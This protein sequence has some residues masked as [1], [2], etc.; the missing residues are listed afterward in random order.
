MTGRPGRVPRIGASRAGVGLAIVLLA[1]GDASPP[2]S[3]SARLP[4][5]APSVPAVR[6]PAVPERIE[7]L[8]PATP[9][10][11]WN[12][13]LVSIDTLRA[14]HLSAYGYDRPTSPSIDAL[15]ASGL[16]FRQAYSHSPKTTPSHMTLMTSLYPAVHRVLNRTGREIDSRL[17]PDI[18]T[19]PEMLHRAGY[20]SAAFTA[21]G[22]MNGGIGF[23]RGFDRFE[24]MP[25]D[26]A[27]TFEAGADALR[28]WQADRDD[29]R[30]FFLFLHT[31]QV[32]GPY[33]PPP[34]D[35]ALFVDPDYAG[36]IVSD[37]ER[38]AARAAASGRSL[39]TEF[40]A[41][42]DPR[43]PRE[44]Q[45]LRNLYDACIHYTDAQIGRLLE[46]VDELG[47]RDTTAV[48]LLADHGEEFMEHGGLRHNSVF[49]ELLHVPLIVRLPP[50]AGLDAHGIVEPS[51]R[52]VDVTP[53]LLDLVGLPT[54]GH[55]QGSSL[56]PR[57]RGTGDPPRFVFAHWRERGV[58]SLRSG[59]FKLIRIHEDLHVFDL[60]TDPAERHPVEAEHP[61]VL[62][63]LARDLK[64]LMEASRATAAR[65]APGDATSLDP[66]TRERLRALGY[67]D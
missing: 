32:H 17:S 3:A 8:A 50:A 16:L 31:V 47:L 18:P 39:A 23:A 2:G 63:R 38:L 45:H 65:V 24:H 52:L 10:H 15:A 37:R 34:T 57:I 64:R 25:V 44:L 36:P 5:N 49:E 20:R 7:P 19:L 29:R 53:T 11:P 56:L 55:L 41:T 40:W 51:V 61:A 30:P 58:R 12:V 14:D 9:A 27:P 59:R 22:N 1:C 26:A 46:V 66:A 42:A 13:I 48:V 33:L 62:A 4:G 28:R 35:R 67:L 6:V 54:P 60:L 21:G 43:S